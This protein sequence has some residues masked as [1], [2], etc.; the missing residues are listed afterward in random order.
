MRLLI[1]NPN[2]TASMTAKIGKAAAAAPVSLEGFE[3]SHVD[4]SS[5][6]TQPHP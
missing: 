3:E 4:W 1:I 2:T 5:F 6:I